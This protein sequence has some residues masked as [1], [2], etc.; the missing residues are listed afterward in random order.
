[1]NVRYVTAKMLLHLSQLSLIPSNQVQTALNNLLIDPSSKENLW[2]V[3]DQGNAWM[4]CVYYNAGP[5]NDVV[6]SLLIQ[7][8][9]GDI[10]TIIRRNELNNIDASFN[11]S[12][13]AAHIDSHETA[14]E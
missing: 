2:L 8:L 10:N 1:M 9:T 3:K 5:F 11:E 4:E 6:Y 7:H 13:Q 14:D 12:E